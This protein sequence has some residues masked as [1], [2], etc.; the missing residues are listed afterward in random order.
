M[1]QNNKLHVQNGADVL[2]WS[3]YITTFLFSSVS[4]RNPDTHRC[5]GTTVEGFRQYSIRVWLGGGSGCGEFC[6]YGDR[7]TSNLYQRGEELH[8]WKRHQ[9]QQQYP[10]P[11]CPGEHPAR[12]QRHTWAGWDE[13]QNANNVIHKEHRTTMNEK[14]TPIPYL[15]FPTFIWVCFS[16]EQYFSDGVTSVE[17]GYLLNESLRTNN[18]IESE[19][20][21]QEVLIL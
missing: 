11:T 2:R 4:P 6:L 7:V 19:I 1:K 21:T 18:Q 15:S 17:D 20:R 9:H 12:C 8:S 13:K 3:I 14:N 10:V 16:F 5:G